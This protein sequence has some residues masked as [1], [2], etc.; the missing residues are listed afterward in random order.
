MAYGEKPLV[1]LKNM[2]EANQS[3]GLFLRDIGQ[4]CIVYNV[5]RMHDKT[6]VDARGDMQDSLWFENELDLPVTAEATSMFIYATDEK[7]P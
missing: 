5:F 4:S 7:A 3:C 2:F 1:L 6:S